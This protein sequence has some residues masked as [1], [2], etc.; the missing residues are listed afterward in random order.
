MKTLALRLPHLSPHVAGV[1]AALSCAAAILGVMVW[2]L[3]IAVSSGVVP[4]P[5]QVPGARVQPPADTALPI[6]GKTRGVP[7]T[8]TRCPG[9]GEIV[10]MREIGSGVE[11]PVIVVMDAS[12]A[13]GRDDPKAE[14]VR[15]YEIIVRMNDGS[16]RV[17][18]HSSPANWRPGERVMIIDGLNPSGK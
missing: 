8:R 3:A 1:A 5:D 7:R 9:C 4:V 13:D 10:S 2:Q 16:Q 11:A 6:S 12:M 14:S 15:G 17:F 18:N